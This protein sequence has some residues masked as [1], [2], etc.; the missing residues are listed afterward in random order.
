MITAEAKL[1]INPQCFS[2][3]N[4]DE[5]NGVDD[6]DGNSEGYSCNLGYALTAR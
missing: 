4:E 3:Y 5:D 6:D 2:E 1:S